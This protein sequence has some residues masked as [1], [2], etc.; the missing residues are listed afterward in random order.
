ML[1]ATINP[2]NNNQRLAGRALAT[3]ISEGL[4]VCLLFCN[5][6]PAPNTPGFEANA[7]NQPPNNGGKDPARPRAIL[8][9]EWGELCAGNCYNDA[10]LLMRRLPLFFG[11]NF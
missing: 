11:F 9:L 4:Y 7:I 2:N 8:R 3:A 5:N 10:L 1:F 6:Q